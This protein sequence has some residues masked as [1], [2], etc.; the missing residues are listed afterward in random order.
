MKPENL[1]GAFT[2]GSAGGAISCPVVFSLACVFFF[3]LALTLAI[4]A[5]GR[6]EQVLLKNHL[7]R[8]ADIYWGSFSTRYYNVVHPSFKINKV[9]LIL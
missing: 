7:I 3:G 4:S 2:D 9:Y 1:R 8:K 5:T 6:S